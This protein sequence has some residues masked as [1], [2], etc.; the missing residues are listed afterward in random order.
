MSFDA[1]RCIHSRHCV[2]ELPRVFQANTPGTWLF[3]NEAESEQLAAVIRECP[4]G[5]LQYERLDDR[6]AE[7]SPAVNLIHVQENGPYAVLADM[8]LG[9]RN[10]G[11]RATLCR[12]GESKN[13]PLCDGS[14]AAAQFKAARRQRWTQRLYPSEVAGSASIP[15]RTGRSRSRATWSCA[16]VQAA[17]SC[18]PS[19]CACADADIRR[20][21]PCAMALTSQRASCRRSQLPPSVTVPHDRGVVGI[22]KLDDAVRCVAVVVDDRQQA[23]LRAYFAQVRRSFHNY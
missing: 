6:P 11:Y 8:D 13:K 14:H 20:R 5:A 2:T 10:V 21:S 19:R 16:P 15:L 9:G 12:C 23:L 17:S 3:P 7:P 4:S 22:V 18:V 1:K